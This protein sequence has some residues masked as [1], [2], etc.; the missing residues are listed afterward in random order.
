M[1]YVLK[2]KDEII[3]LVDFLEDGSTYKFHQ[4]LVNPEIALL[5][6]PDFV[7]SGRDRHLGNVSILRDSETLQFISPAPIYDSGKCLFVQDSKMDDH[8][9]AMIGEGYKRKIDLFRRFQLGE[10]LNKIK[11][12]VSKQRSAA[13]DTKDIIISEEREKKQP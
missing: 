10:N 12:S 7:L 8:R 9:I 4:D 11:F 2:R 3:T 13:I 1:L 6:A 5:H